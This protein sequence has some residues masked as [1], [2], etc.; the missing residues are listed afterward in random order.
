[1]RMSPV[2]LPGGPAPRCV[3]T[4]R[5]EVRD[6]CSTLK[7]VS[8][9]GGGLV[10]FAGQTARPQYPPS[11]C[12]AELHGRHAPS[13]PTVQRRRSGLA[14]ALPQ[15]SLQDEHLLAKGQDLAVT[16]VT[17]QASGHRE[18][19]RQEDEKQVPEHAGRM[20]GLQDEVNSGSE[21]SPTD[22]GSPQR[23]RRLVLGPYGSALPRG[24]TVR[25]GLSSHWRPS[26]PECMFWTQ[27][28]SDTS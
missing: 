28:G 3:P 13:E 15:L 6:S 12:Y 17:E 8:E 19:G 5:R 20:T 23:P 7:P 10:A 25:P 11:T 21:S 4:G 18:Q 9:L 14:R 2:R 1:M 24:T 16:I 27:A 26:P 22:A